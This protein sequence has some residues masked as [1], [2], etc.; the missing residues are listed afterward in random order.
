LIVGAGGLGAPAAS[1]LAG[2]GVGTIGIIDPDRVELTNLHRQL[3]YGDADIGRPKVAAARDYLRRVALSV[4]VDVMEDRLDANNAARVIAGYDVVIDASD[5]FETKFLINDVAV[6]SGT[7]FSH[8]GV[9]GLLGQTMTVVPGRSACVRCL[10][11][12]PPPAGTTP[13]CQDAGILGPVAGAIGAIQAAETI[14]LLLDDHSALLDRLLTY[15]ALRNRWRAVDL[16]RDPRCPVCASV[17]PARR[18]PFAVSD[19]LASESTL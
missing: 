13:S 17:A 5:N 18:R 9:V 11:G 2:A 16:R 4:T 8:G 7:P 12:G 15:D 3:V 19:R 6:G 1:H 10:F 14:A